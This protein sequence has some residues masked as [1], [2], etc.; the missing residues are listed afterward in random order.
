MIRLLWIGLGGCVG[1][2]LRYGLSLW[3]AGLLGVAF[4]YGTLLVNGIGSF[5]MGVLMWV[6]VNTSILGSTTTLAL[7]TGLLGGFTTYSAFS[8][9]TLMLL[10]QRAWMSAGVNLLGTLVTCLAAV[11]MGWGIA[12]VAFGK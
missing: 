10:Q 3:S 12:S 5:L 7:T 2:I 6:G 11:A 9:E 8:Y 1:S 4:P